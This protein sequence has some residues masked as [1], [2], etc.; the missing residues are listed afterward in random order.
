MPTCWLCKKRT[1][2][3]HSSTEAEINFLDAGLRMDGIPALDLLD[4]IIDVI[5]SFPNVSNN[6]KYQVR[7]NLSRNTTSNKHTQNQTKVPIHHDSLE[8]SNVDYVS[9][10]AKSSQLL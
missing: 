3:S 6:T 4:L 7:G 2:V 9:S 1:I 8:L 10:K 5:H